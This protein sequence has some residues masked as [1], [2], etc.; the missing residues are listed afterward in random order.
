MSATFL[1]NIL[2]IFTEAIKSSLGIAGMTVVLLYFLAVKIINHASDRMKMAVFFSFTIVA[3]VILFLAVKNS[4]TAQAI[5]NNLNSSPSPAP[6]QS[7]QTAL[8]QLP[9]PESKHRHPSAR[10]T[11]IPTAAPTP[12]ITATPIPPSI[13]WKW[14]GDSPTFYF[15]GSPYCNYSGILKNISVLLT[16]DPNQTINSSSVTCQYIE[17]GLGCPY[18]TIPPTGN[19][20][21]LA[22]P[23]TLNSQGV[24]CSYSPDPHN[25]PICSLSFEGKMADGALNGRLI[26]KR[27]DSSGNLNWPVTVDMVLQK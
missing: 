20:Y 11:V 8:A 3:L 25:G 1:N 24:T 5:T 2:P 10:H 23:A 12:K 6:T 14:T 9:R 27:I 15:G 13:V 7:L 22:G 4:P 17:N 16:L 26:F 21:T 18:G 19:Q